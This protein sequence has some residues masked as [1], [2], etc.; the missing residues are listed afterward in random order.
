MV[1]GV[2]LVVFDIEPGRPQLLVRAAR[3]VD[4]HDRVAPTVCDECA[5]PAGPVREV[6]L[7]ALDDRDEAR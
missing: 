5:R 4:G 6:G 2:G 3:E 1:A 7:P